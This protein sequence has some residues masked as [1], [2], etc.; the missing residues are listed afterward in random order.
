MNTEAKF[1]EIIEVAQAAGLHTVIRNNEVTAY[2]VSTSDFN[3]SNGRPPAVRATV[4]DNGRKTIAFTYMGVRS[5]TI[6]RIEALQTL[7]D[8]ID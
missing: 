6:T 1:E 2:L 3:A 5:K 4:R 8:C 7:T